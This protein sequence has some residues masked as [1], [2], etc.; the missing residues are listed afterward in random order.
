MTAA[1]V[2]ALGSLLHARLAHDAA[3]RMAAARSQNG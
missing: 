3:T 1:A 2:P